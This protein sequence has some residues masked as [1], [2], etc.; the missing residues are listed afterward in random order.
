MEASKLKA[1]ILGEKL[2]EKVVVTTTTTTARLVV[3]KKESL[4]S[5]KRIIKGWVWNVDCHGP[6]SA[7]SLSLSCYLISL[8]IFFVLVSKKKNKKLF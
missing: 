2:K 6:I 5:K 3:K 7:F 1:K 4:V 8:F